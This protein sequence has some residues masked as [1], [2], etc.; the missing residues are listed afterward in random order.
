MNAYIGP[1]DGWQTG[2][3]KN[4]PKE[5]DISGIS[6]AELFV[7]IDEREDSINDGFFLVNMTGYQPAQPNLNWIVDFPASYHNKAGSLSFADGHAE[8]HKW[9]DPR[10]MPILRKGAKLKLHVPSK[11]NKDIT[12][13]QSKSS[14]LQ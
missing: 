4:F 13:L 7:F 6:P 5:S 14:R 8:I 12:W 2:G 3:Y 1:R 11:N 9:L 10:T